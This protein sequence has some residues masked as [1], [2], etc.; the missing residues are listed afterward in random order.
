MLFHDKLA[1]SIILAVLSKEELRTM[2]THVIEVER[3]ASNVLTCLLLRHIFDR[4]SQGSLITFQLYWNMMNNAFI[5]LGKHRCTV[6]K[7][8]LP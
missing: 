8:Y 6:R 7:I 4:H 2:N 5:S 3:K 1:C